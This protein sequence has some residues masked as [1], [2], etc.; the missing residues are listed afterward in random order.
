[1]LRICMLNP[2]V[3]W[4]PLLASPVR[5]GILNHYNLHLL[6]CLVYN[7]PW[8]SPAWTLHFFDLLQEDLTI[9]CTRY[10]NTE[11]LTFGDLN[12]TLGGWQEPVYSEHNE[13][14]HPLRHVPVRGA[15]DSITSDQQ[16]GLRDLIGMSEPYLLNGP[17]SDKVGSYMFI[18]DKG[19]STNDHIRWTLQ[20]GT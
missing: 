20:Q 15:I 4:S 14:G 1:M 11:L 8:N 9:F 2:S 3:C 19:C 5:W 12:I 17:F 13:L 7:P 18:N 10:P 16:D 6:L